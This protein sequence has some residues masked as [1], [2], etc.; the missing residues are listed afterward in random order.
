MNLRYP[1]ISIVLIVLISLTGSGC[2][3][4]SPQEAA[5]GVVTDFLTA[6]NE[7]DYN[8]AFNL[9]RGKDFLATA[10]IR[11]S[12]SNKGMDPGNIQQIEIRSLEI[13]DNVAVV[14]ADCSV[15]SQA[16]PGITNVVPVYFRVQ[17]SEIGWIITRVSFNSPLTLEDVE[18]LD[19]E[20]ESTPVDL[21]V[22]NAAMVSAFA[23]I[24]LGSGL[25]LDRK[26]KAKKKEDSRTINVS[27]AVPIQKEVIAKYMRFVPPQQ[28]TVGKYHNIE[29]WVKNFTQ[30]PYENFAVKAK[31]ANSME[32][33]KINLFFDTIAPGETAKRTW[34]INPK[35]SGW[36]PIEGPT[37]VFEYMG[38]KY[39]C[40][41]DPLWLQVQ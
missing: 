26:D 39:I 29:V 12:F 1:S 36:V 30:H 8:T 21:I 22:D 14:T 38:T 19:L 15:S 37:V 13:S 6:V 11:M 28:F 7:G 40:V 33:K 4:Q 41:M 24:M 32:V 35:L 34:T 3:T 10:S 9:Y 17:N 23:F 18:T 25:Y 27:G 20:L 16:T 5:E 31:F 2:V